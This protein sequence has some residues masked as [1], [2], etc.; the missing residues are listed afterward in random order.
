MPVYEYGC[1]KCGTK[2]THI[3][4]V[5][6]RNRRL[7]CACG[8]SMRMLV[9]SFTP[10]TDTNFWYTGKY[11]SRLG[12]RIEG[13]RDWERKLKDKGLQEIQDKDF[14]VT[15]TTEERIDKY[16]PPLEMD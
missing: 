16:C 1:E 3:R 8:G 9:S 15:T 2:T 7:L 13:R 10:I 4:D 11:D 5:K 12:S 6:Y 14:A